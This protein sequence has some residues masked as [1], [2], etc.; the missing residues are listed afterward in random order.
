MDK[1]KLAGNQAATLRPHSEVEAYIDRGL[2]NLGRSKAQITQAIANDR[3]QAASARA[4]A[5]AVTSKVEPV[6]AEAE[7][8]STPPPAAPPHRRRLPHGQRTLI[9][10]L[11]FATGM[12]SAGPSTWSGRASSRSIHRG[13]RTRNRAK[14]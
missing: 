6:R 10:A 5:E 12:A 8:Q 14:P 13:K 2:A 11:S 9:A 7:P 4:A 1:R 3:Q